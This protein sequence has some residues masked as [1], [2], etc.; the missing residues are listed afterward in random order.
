MLLASVVLDPLVQL[1]PAV[2]LVDDVVQEMTQPGQDSA[3]GSVGKVPLFVA[4]VSQ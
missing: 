1:P 2:W 4:K 3:A